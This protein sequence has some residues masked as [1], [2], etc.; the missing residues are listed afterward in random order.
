M[1]NDDTTIQALRDALAVSPDNIPLRLHLAQVL[2]GREEFEDA[3]KE[4]RKALTIDPGNRDV[5]LG[6]SRS[7]ERQG[8]NSAALVVLEE[9]L[10]SGDDADV[11]AIYAKVLLRSGQKEDARSA[12]E[13]GLA[14]N[15]DRRDDVLD[16]QLGMNPKAMQSG[17]DVVEGRMRYS[18]DDDFSD[19]DILTEL[20]D[21]DIDFSS[22]GGMEDVKDEIRLKIIMPL[23]NKDLY[24][25]YGKKAGG[26]IL[27][28]GPPGCGKTHLARATAGEVN[29]KFISVGL[30]DV[31]NMWIGQSEERLHKIFEQ[32]R[33]NKPCILFFDEVDALGAKR[34]DMRQSAGRHLINQFLSELDGVD[35]D[36]EGVLILAATN[37]PWHLDSA[38]R[39]PGR[40]DR[41]IFVPPPDCVARIEILRIMTQDMPTEGLDLTKLAKKLEAYSGADLRAVIDV[42]VES[43]L[44]DAMKTGV[45]A[46]LTVKDLLKAAK[47]VRQSTKEWFAT[48][49]NYAIYS[50]DS[51]LYDDILDYLNIRR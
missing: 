19:D 14:I 27:M 31:L 7:Y 29:A 5:K 41:I 8:K 13:R 30:N 38:F 34:S 50:N 1:A 43:K 10:D 40:F 21:S 17:A 48:A 47:Q 26:G 37:A 18:S 22:V 11:L 45:P 16:K 2:L 33:R 44:R 25:A 51:G 36:N 12:Y 49:K 9:L 6:L 23:Q 39:R 46:P 42:A 3:E 32:A 24:A 15:P 28:Y 4:L 35:A 20:Q